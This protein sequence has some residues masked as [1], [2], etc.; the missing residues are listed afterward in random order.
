MATEERNRLSSSRRNAL[1]NVVRLIPAFV[2]MAVMLYTASCSNNGPFSDNGSGSNSPT[3]TPTTGTG[4][5]AFVTNFNDGKVS[6]FTRNPTTGVLKRT[7]Q[8]TAGAKKG[9]KGVVAAPSGSFLYVANN[10]DG[11]IYQF[12]INPT[13][14]TLTPLSPAFI[15][16]G[17]GSGPDEIAIN[18]AGT[19]LWVTGASATKGTVTPYSINSSTGQLT[20]IS[21]KV[22]GL[23]SPFGIAVDSTN[24]IVYVADHVAG[25]VYSYSIGSSGALTQIGSPVQDLGS[26][27]G[28]PDFIAID[29]AGTFIYVTD[30][31][32]GVLS[33]I[34]TTSGTL[35][36]SSILPTTTSGNV[37]IG[38]GYGSVSTV[39]NFVF[40]ANQG[41]S[42]LWSFLLT[43]AGSPSSPVEFGTGDL[44]APTGLVVDPQNAFLYTTNQNAGTVSQ[45]SL[46][47]TC[48][49]AGA[50]CF[51]GSVATESPA[52][53][54]SGPFGITLA[55]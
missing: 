33:V 14:G 25:L 21:T 10:S 27:G 18:T 3:A 34:Q 24:S 53:A 40:T 12:S 15:S 4:A 50:P 44:N 29:P 28:T 17:S 52:N 51:V 43:I 26:P 47:A 36:F 2:I 54:N 41:N 39:G 7:E 20:Q 8:V 11:N 38:I 42:T 30:H 55:Q 19:F 1:K 49:A 16:N 37:P 35:A 5:L 13:N 23:V 46:S 22:T 32:A 31:D 9:P 48:F 6:S 45:F